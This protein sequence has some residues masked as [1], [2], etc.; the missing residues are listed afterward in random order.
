MNKLFAADEK[1]IREGYTKDVYFEHTKQ[2]LEAKG[3]EDLEVSMEFTSG[4]LPCGWEWG[5]FCGLEEVLRL[6]EGMKVSIYAVPEGTVFRSRTSASVRSPV[7]NFQG[8][9]MDFGVMETAILGMICQPTG[10]ATKAARMKLA[11]KGKPVI[12]FGNRRMHPAISGVLDRSAYVGGC[13][14]VS[15]QA[16]GDLIGKKPLGTT[17]H[18]LPLMMGSNDVAFR[19]FD[20]YIDPSVPRIMLIDTFS[21]ERTAAVEACKTVKNLVGVRLDTPGS[22]RGNF[23]ELIDEVRWEMDMNGFE[24]VKIIVSGGLD[25]N[26][27]AALADTCVSSFGVGT[28]ISNAPTLDFS[29]DLVEKNGVPMAKRGKFAGRK[30]PYRCPDCFTMGV[31]LQPDMKIICECGREMEMIEKQVMKDGRRTVPEVKPSEIRDYV[32]RQ[33]ETLEKNG[34]F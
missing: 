32:I 8:K 14:D 11:A 29:M 20:E 24:H 34:D 3:L 26:T 18:V 10:V 25:E 21:D 17:P 1:D 33:L 12:A 7:M 13:D 16:G 5:V 2:I 30:Y 23:K 31:S 19:A 15:S 22:R 9:Y 27:V 28:S 4:S 6:M